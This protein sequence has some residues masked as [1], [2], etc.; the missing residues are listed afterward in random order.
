MRGGAKGQKWL[1]AIFNVAQRRPE[2]AAMDGKPQKRRE[3]FC[4]QAPKG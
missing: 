2:V 4:A 3:R 1:G